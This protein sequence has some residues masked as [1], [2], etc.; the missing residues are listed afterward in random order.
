MADDPAPDP[1]SGDAPSRTPED[2]TGR[3]PAAVAVAVHLGA[4]GYDTAWPTDRAAPDC[5]LSPIDGADPPLARV[6]SS[7]DLAVEA[8]PSAEPTTVIDAVATAVRGGR[9][10]LLA[11]DR[12][13]ALDA[14][15]V[16][17]DPPAVRA[18]DEEGHRT[19]YHVPDRLRVGEAGFGA[20]RADGDLVWREEAG[21]GV[22]GDGRTRLALEADG[23]VQAVFDG[24]PALACPAPGAFP[25]TYRRE[26]DRRIHV[27]D[28]DGHEVGVYPTIRAMKANAYRPVP[29]PLVPEVHLPG[30]VR[31]SQAWAIAVVEDGDVVEFLTA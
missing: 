3:P 9:F 6:E 13:T 24:Y 27:L 25:Y 12:R 15:A 19:F 17:T 8:L 20:V 5:V 16:L 1:R 11:A 4:R 2:D 7:R 28:R 30:D 31:L 26:A 14:R 21:G 23:R 10:A 18:V 29:D 22:T